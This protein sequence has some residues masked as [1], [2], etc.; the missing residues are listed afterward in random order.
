[1]KVFGESK[2]LEVETAIE[3]AKLELAERPVRIKRDVAK[4]IISSYYFSLP[5]AD[6]PTLDRETVIK[7]VM[8]GTPVEEALA[9]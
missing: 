5:K 3:L 2:G 8:E 7:M 4:E 6:R 9:A 1:M